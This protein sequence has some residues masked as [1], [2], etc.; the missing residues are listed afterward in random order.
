MTRNNLHVEIAE[1]SRALK[2]ELP[3]VIY[4]K[5]TTGNALVDIAKKVQRLATKASRLRRE[6]KRA[7]ADLKAEKRNLRALMLELRGRDGQEGQTS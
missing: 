3:S 1:A 4:R 5:P 2:T 7:E 6:L